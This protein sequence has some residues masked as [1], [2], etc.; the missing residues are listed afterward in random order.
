MCHLLDPAALPRVLSLGLQELPDAKWKVMPVSPYWARNGLTATL[1]GVPTWSVMLGWA[2][3]ARMNLPLSSLPQGP[4][5]IKCPSLRTSLPSVRS[6]HANT[7]PGRGPT[8][9]WPDSTQPSLPAV[10]VPLVSPSV[11]L[12][13]ILHPLRLSSQRTPRW[14]VHNSGTVLL[15]SWTRGISFAQS[16]ARRLSQSPRPC[17]SPYK[18]SSQLPL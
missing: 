9:P 1:R 16:A 14:I 13:C 8:V 15:L 7:C 5:T 3:D 6:T 17:E 4:C 12:W 10:L 2:P 11:P 18:E